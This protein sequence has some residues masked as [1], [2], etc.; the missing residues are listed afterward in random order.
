MPDIVAGVQEQLSVP[1]E[2]QGA[3]GLVHFVCP[4][5]IFSSSLSQFSLSSVHDLM[6]V[7]RL[8]EVPLGGLGELLLLELR[9]LHH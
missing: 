8:S 4:L 9:L 5:Q 3:R 7:L 1:V 6:Q 2:L